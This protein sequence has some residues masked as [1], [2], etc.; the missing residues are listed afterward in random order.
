MRL[1]RQRIRAMSKLGESLRTGLSVADTRR[2]LTGAFAEAGIDAPELDARLLVGHALGLDHAGLVT[3]ADRSLSEDEIN[4][5]ADGTA[6]RL[7]GE[8]VA[9]ILGVKEFWGLPIRL[10]A[11]VLVP[12]PDT[13]TVVEAALDALD[14]EGLRTRALRIADLGTGSGALLL[15]LLTELPHAFGVGTDISGGAIAA[16]RINA[17]ALGLGDRAA[18][19]VCDFGAALA[20][21]FDL[22]VSNPPYVRS[23]DIAMLKPDVRDHD[24]RLALDGGVDG[25]AAYRA[26]AADARPLLAPHGHLVVELG[27][28]AATAVAQA[29]AAAGL[30]AAGAPRCDLAGIARALHVKHPG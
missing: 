5:V 3:A 22:V 20:G 21:G 30:A 14:R 18:F 12:R 23:A 4:L 24:P 29:F 13:E 6:R 26:I 17:D 7:A 11:S 28:G 2:A 19:V 16:A 9:R 27:A 15:A 8:P 10:N 1:E 25:L